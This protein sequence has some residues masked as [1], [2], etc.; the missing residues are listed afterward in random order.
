MLL[1]VYEY[2]TQGLP[3]LGNWPDP[4]GF[5][6]RNTHKTLTGRS[7]TL[8]CARVAGMAGPGV[9]LVQCSFPSVSQLPQRLGCG[10]TSILN[11]ANA[12]TIEAHAPGEGRE[13]GI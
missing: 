6:K 11:N 3:S 7:H 13:I 5:K 1:N 2:R 9:C 12:I 10:I 8:V 4:F